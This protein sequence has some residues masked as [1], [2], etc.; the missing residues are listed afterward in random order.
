MC[1]CVHAGAQMHT[2][3]LDLGKFTLHPEKPVLMIC[4]SAGVRNLVF[5]SQLHLSPFLWMDG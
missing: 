4:I 3:L 2:L 1:S 5:D